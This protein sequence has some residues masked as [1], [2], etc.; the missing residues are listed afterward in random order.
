MWQ[1]QFALP[2]SA[3]NS[4][5]IVQQVTATVNG[6]VQAQWW[7]AYYIAQFNKTTVGIYNTAY[8]DQ[9]VLPSSPNTMGMQSLQGIAEFYEGS[10]PSGFVRGS[11]P[12]AGCLRATTNQPDFWTAAGTPHSLTVS[13][14]CTDGNADPNTSVQTV[15]PGSCP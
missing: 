13:W 7:E 5:W 10:L 11:V 2:Q 15:P 9:F 6:S 14:D 1:V 12:N 8:D 3:A 4:G